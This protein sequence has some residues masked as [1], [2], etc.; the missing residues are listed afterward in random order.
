[1]L[2]YSSDCPIEL[3][4]ASMVK[5]LTPLDVALLGLH[6]YSRYN[7]CG[8]DPSAPDYE[9][10]ACACVGCANAAVR[11]LGLTYQDWAAWVK[12]YPRP[13]Q[14]DDVAWVLLLDAWE[15]QYREKWMQ[16]LE[17]QKQP[18]LQDRLA[19]YRRKKAAR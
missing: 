11:E 19:A 2:V 15:S 6:P 5:R 3:G 16:W 13:A 4:F 12:R 10:F 8:G 17:H 1:M 7:W 14:E 9:A 18:T